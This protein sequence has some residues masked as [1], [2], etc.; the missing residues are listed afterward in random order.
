MEGKL[1][2]TY[3][4]TPY[5]L[6]MLASALF[7][8]VLVVY[9]WRRRSVPGALPLAVSMLSTLPWSVGA[10]LQLA[11]VDAPTKIF[12]VKLQPLWLFVSVS[13][14]LCFSL[15]YANLRRWLTRRTVILLAL[16]ILILVLLMVTNEAHHLLWLGFTF[17]EQ[18]QPVRGIGLWILTIYGYAL[19][20]FHLGIMLWLFLRSPQHRWPVGLILCGQPL[21]SIG[22]LLDISNRNPLA[23][24]NLGVLM[25]IFT[26]AAYSFAL[27]RFRLFDP[28]PLAHK[29]V[30]EQMREG[31][32]V[33]DTQHQIVD[34]N[35]AAEKIL[36]IS[37]AHAKARKIDQLLNLRLD[38]SALQQSEIIIGNDEL[39]R[40]FAVHLSALIDQRGFP[41]G[42]LIL[43][44]DVT[45]QKRAQAQLLEQQRALAAS[46][47]RAMVARELHDELA[48]NLAFINVEAQAAS[49]LLTDGDSQQ[50]VARLA[51]LAKVARET[52]ADA[53]EQISN[54]S[55]DMLSPARFLDAVR[56]LVETFSRTYGIPVELILP[57]TQSAVVLEPT[58][59]VGLVRII[60][61]ALTN[62]RKHACAQNVQVILAMIPT[63]LEVIVTDDGNGFDPRGCADNGGTFGMRIMGERAAEIGG[64]LQ[65]ESVV[66]HGTRVIVRVPTSPTVPP[67]GIGETR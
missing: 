32:L 7:T 43:L 59:E 61:E 54:L 16:P 50:A 66:G 40:I 42:Y 35:P 17:G 8:A 30:I 55:L 33:L 36:N 37:T 53:R 10:A 49:D 39:A 51:S 52:Y 45:E 38:D 34:L 27:V 23:P 65:V 1:N 29:T 44:H 41:L 24:M 46:K 67:N 3:Q 9:V 64:N 21:T 25:L 62:I 19:I 12:F 6:P 18:V 31:M 11:A 14:L 48:Q 4:F 26:S 15:E 13:A 60:Q 47:E 20:A 58:A 57:D 63:G 28:I 5:M 22:T 56:R 2:S